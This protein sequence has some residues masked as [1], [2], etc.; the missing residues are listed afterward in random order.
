MREFDKLFDYVRGNAGTSPVVRFPARWF[1][2]GKGEIEMPY[3]EAVRRTLEVVDSLR[4]RKIDYSKSLSSAVG[5]N[6]SGGDW[7]KSSIIYNMF[8]RVASAWDHDGDGVIGGS[9]DDITLNS[10]GVRETGTFLKALIMLPYI[11]SLGADL[12]YLQP[13]MSLGKAYRKGELSGP[14]AVRNPFKLEETL[15]DP[16]VDDVLSIEE[17]FKVFVESAHILG[18]RV[19]LDFVPRT[20]SRDSDWIPE[21]PDWFYWI[22]RE[23]DE[24]FHSPEF[25]REE[26]DRIHNAV[27]RG[28]FDELIPPHNDYINMFA[29]PPDKSTIKHISDEV[30]YV[31]TVNGREVVVPGAF[32]DWPPDDVQPPWTDVTYLKLFKD[33]DFNY[34][35][36]NTVRMYDARIRDRNEELWEVIAGIPAFYAENFGVDGARI[37]MGHALPPELE[38]NMIKRAREVEPDFAFL[39]EDFD[40]NSETTKHGYNAV[41]GNSWWAFP[42][43]SAD[44]SSPGKRFLKDVLV[45]TNH[46]V[47]APE[48][49]DTPRAAYRPGGTA[50]STMAYA[51]SV[52]LPNTIPFIH[53]GF[54]LAETK[55]TNLGLDFTPEE[56][57]KLSKEPILFFQRGALNWK[58][59]VDLDKFV[60]EMNKLRRKVA[61][62]L[63]EGRFKI[64]GLDDVSELLTFEFPDVVV[65]VNLN[66]K[67]FTKLPDDFM[68]GMWKSIRVFGGSVESG[69]ISAGGVVVKEM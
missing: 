59:D 24:N 51:V 35:A 55:H 45:L 25:T 62:A 28:A 11:K 7:I 67:D 2:K 50:Y 4:D 19:I 33:E 66:M 21:H 64:S 56:I 27:N 36:Y 46:I 22:Y 5:V 12:I 42:R 41:A 20:A 14:Y 40:I 8:I 61:P 29:P 57:D 58:S 26:L 6:P 44:P 32:A 3:L 60:E 30:G 13:I 52:L 47:A 68:S 49:H 31:G 9:G 53:A 16:M 63:K 48:T 17:Q 23:Y 65:Y 43:L 39:S 37:D 69:K 38:Q 10:R 1:G 54:E 34:V 18:M 15:S